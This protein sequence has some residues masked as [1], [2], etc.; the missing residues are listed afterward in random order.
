[1]DYNGVIINNKVSTSM[2][3]KKMI[4]VIKWRY[5]PRSKIEISTKFIGRE[6]VRKLV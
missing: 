1:M 5:L 2:A 3:V 6:S 4:E